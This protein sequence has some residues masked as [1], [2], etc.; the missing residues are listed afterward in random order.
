MGRTRKEA[1]L[2]ELNAYVEIYPEFIEDVQK[3]MAKKKNG[4]ETPWSECPWSYSVKDITKVD[5][6]SARTCKLYIHRLQERI[7]ECKAEIA[8]LNAEN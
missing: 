4:D 8:K 2:S 5:T 3:F 6:I 1:K 7:S